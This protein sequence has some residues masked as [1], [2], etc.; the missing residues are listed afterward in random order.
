[1]RSIWR[2]AMTGFTAA[3]MNP[4]PTRAADLETS[5]GPLGQA[6]A[7]RRF[8]SLAAGVPLAQAGGIKA[9]AVTSDT[10]LAM[11]PDIPTF[12]EMGLPAV[13]YS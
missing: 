8:L 13:S 7:R 2:N 9:Y 5:I 11:A 10:R 12:A 1:M 3:A 4:P 6:L